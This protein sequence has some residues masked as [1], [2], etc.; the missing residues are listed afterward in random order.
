MLSREVWRLKDRAALV[1]GLGCAHVCSTSCFFSCLP[2]DGD[3][4]GAHM[5][6]EVQPSRDTSNQQ[7]AW[8]EIRFIGE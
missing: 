5:K 6:A 8:W 1:V 2:H 3:C 7:V 4:Q